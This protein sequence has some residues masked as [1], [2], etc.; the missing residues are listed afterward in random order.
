MFAFPP[1]FIWFAE[2]CSLSS[3]I[4]FK[5]VVTVHCFPLQLACVVFL[6]QVKHLKTWCH[7]ES[8][9]N[10]LT[11]KVLNMFLKDSRTHKTGWISACKYPGLGFQGVSTEVSPYARTLL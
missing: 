4:W 1:T 9:E 6:F 8:K 2:N 3:N 10:V 11:T 7:S 5:N